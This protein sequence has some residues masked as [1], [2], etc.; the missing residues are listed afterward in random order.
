MGALPY[1]HKG[2]I[3]LVVCLYTPTSD[4]ANIYGQRTLLDLERWKLHPEDYPLRCK[5][6]LWR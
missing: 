2:S 3:R 1:G 4:E 5:W 6:V